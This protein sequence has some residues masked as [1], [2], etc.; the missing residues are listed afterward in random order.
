V[1]RFFDFHSFLFF[2][3]FLQFSYSFSFFRTDNDFRGPVVEYG[4]PTSIMGNQWWSSDRTFYFTAPHRI[5]NGWID[6][7]RVLRVSSDG[8][9]S[10]APM[11]RLPHRVDPQA[12]T[13]LA[14]DMLYLNPQPYYVLSFSAGEKAVYSGKLLLHIYYNSSSNS[15]LIWTFD[16]EGG[17][18]RDPSVSFSIRLTEK[19]DERIRVSIKFGCQLGTTQVTAMTP[20]AA[21]NA[22]Y[23][24]FVASP[25]GF[26]AVLNSSEVLDA[27]RNLKYS[28][29]ARARRNTAAIDRD[30]LAISF[31]ALTSQSSTGPLNLFL[32]SLP[33][34]FTSVNGSRYL[35]YMQDY[36]RKF[37]ITLNIYN[38]D[39][40]VCTPTFY[41]F[42]FLTVPKDWTISCDPKDKLLL[43]G[44]QECSLKCLINTPAISRT[45]DI[46]KNFSIVMVLN[47]ANSS[48][49]SP[50]RSG[51]HEFV[52][53]Y[54]FTCQRSAPTAWIA[55]GTSVSLASLSTSPGQTASVDLY[56]ANPAII[57]PPTDA[58]VLETPR[59]NATTAGVTAFVAFRNND[60]PF[61]TS[62]VET[63]S[64][65][66]FVTL[67][68]SSSLYWTIEGSPNYAVNLKPQSISVLAVRLKPKATFQNES[69]DSLPLSFSINET[70]IA[71]VGETTPAGVYIE[72]ANATVNVLP[73]CDDVP[74]LIELTP[75]PGND[76][77]STTQKGRSSSSP[78]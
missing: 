33:D 31:P 18:W 54:P 70:T 43:V 50:L 41:S 29:S 71:K 52:F 49:S 12:I 69:L 19:T 13:I 72:T 64:R 27:A 45:T 21:S 22:R 23:P 75:D 16:R 3:F 44:D 4:D 2:F 6:A 32:D 35:L 46:G 60:S 61:C 74:M 17:L 26:Q 58:I 10:L 28:Q 5:Q 57:S 9:Y 30:E 8:D 48:Y 66:F 47:G 73:P 76:P 36:T 40:P 68:N 55:D 67:S 53:V 14:P 24:V 15:A 25:T 7:D 56:R 37:N 42:N 78:F 34:S 59:S 63:A 77:N 11:N 38:R 62:Q 39:S 51:F 1:G 65:S 20:P